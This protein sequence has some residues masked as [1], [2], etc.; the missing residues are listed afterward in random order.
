MQGIGCW[1]RDPVF[2]VHVRVGNY[3]ED[4]FAVGL[5]EDDVYYRRLAAEF[6]VFDHEESGA[7]LCSTQEVEVKRDGVGLFLGGEGAIEVGRG[8]S[9]EYGCDIAAVG[10]CDLSKW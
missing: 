9:Q 1:E 7:G 5:R 10:N 4:F 3:A 8:Y 6:G 2:G